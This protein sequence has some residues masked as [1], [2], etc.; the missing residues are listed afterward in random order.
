MLSVDVEL[1]EL[2]KKY[3]SA[4][5]YEEYFC[6]LFAGMYKLPKFFFI[7]NKDK[8][9]VANDFSQE[10]LNELAKVE[11]QLHKAI[12][13]S[14]PS[15]LERTHAGVRIAKELLEQKDLDP[16][17]KKYCE[18]IVKNFSSVHDTN[19]STM[20]NKTTFNPKEAENLDKHLEDLI[21]D[22]NI[23]LTESF[24]QWINSNDEI[25]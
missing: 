8:K 19:I 7:G 12:F 13:S 4:K 16:Q 1:I 5:L 6:D 21:K 23:T 3:G 14:Y 25:F 2:S 24:H 18:W 15:N 10:K 20:Y 22:N 17:I 9:Y 11:M